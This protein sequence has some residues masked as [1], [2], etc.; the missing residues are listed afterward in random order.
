MTAGGVPSRGARAALAGLLACV[1]LSLLAAA[2]LDG[3]CAEPAEPRSQV[4]QMNIAIPPE[5]PSL[6]PA[7][8][9]Q[10]PAKA[11]DFASDPYLKDVCRED[12]P[13]LRFK[14]FES[15]D[16]VYGSPLPVK[17]SGAYFEVRGKGAADANTIYQEVE[18]TIFRD[19][20]MVVEAEQTAPHFSFDRW[21][22]PFAVSDHPFSPSR[23]LQHHRAMGA[24]FPF[25]DLAEIS[26]LD[27]VEAGRPDTGGSHFS[28]NFVSALNF[29]ATRGENLWGRASSFEDREKASK[30]RLYTT[31]THYERALPISDDDLAALKQIASGEKLPL[32]G[33]GNYILI[34][35]GQPARFVAAIDASKDAV[36]LL[37]C[38]GES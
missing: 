38:D 34:S 37:A 11:I 20:E 16:F 27:P 24:T 6:E 32:H 21:D 29:L 23:Q 25:L 10:K 19:V 9:R 36:G 33:R 22:V 30:L 15:Y 3:C 18:A 8:P 26:F 2:G 1:S 28:R 5:L 13:E 31:G 14:R 17:V 4:P 7:R 35:L 12:L